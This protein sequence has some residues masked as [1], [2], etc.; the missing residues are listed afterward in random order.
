VL[1]LSLQLVSLDL[2]KCNK[3]SKISRH[4]NVWIK[5]LNLAS[6]KPK[7]DDS[8]IFAFHG[9]LASEARTINILQSSR[10]VNY[11]PRVTTQFRASL[12]SCPFQS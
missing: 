7:R 6:G 11:D 3:F 2:S 12:Y 9:R 1:S 8:V 4:Q 5:L 10:V